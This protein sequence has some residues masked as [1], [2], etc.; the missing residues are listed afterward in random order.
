VTDA[1]LEDERWIAV[2]QLIA[3]RSFSKSSRLTSFLSYICRCALEG[4]NDE[5][6][7]QQIGIH[8]FE[9]PVNYNPGED[10]IVRTT[11]RQ[12]RQKLA[13]Y[14]QE[15]GSSDEIRVDIPRGGYH[16]TFSPLREAVERDAVGAV[17][18]APVV[19]PPPSGVPSNSLRLQ[20]KEACLVTLALMIGCVATLL[21][22]RAFS[23]NRSHASNM[24]WSSLFT[25]ER[26]TL[27]VT[28]DAGLN[29]YNNLART[30][31]SLGSYV[32]NTY[33]N[34]PEAQPPP[35]YTWPSLA[36]RRYVSFV[37]LQLSDRLQTLATSYQS[38][39]LV[40]FSRDVTPEDLR[41]RNVVLAGSGS[42]NPWIAM[43][44]SKLNFHLQYDGVR[45]SVSVLNSRPIAGEPAEFIAEASGSQKQGYSHGFAYIALTDNLE[46]NGKVLLVEGS[47]VAGVD[48]A[49]SFLM[50]DARMKPILAQ[51]SKRD[52]H[53]EKFEV[54]LSADFLKSSSPDAR[55]LAT[56]F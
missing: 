7:E 4:R 32:N 48:A 3:S 26:P 31:V 55:L 33:L 28:G 49:V 23:G 30:Q 41:N 38:S 35:G 17:D 56:R 44:D 8:G 27:F 50:N 25:S 40:K 22:Q 10:N 45:N 6:T 43:F 19:Q 39:Y 34:T 1:L 11:A 5:I 42:Y 24:L 12:L 54:L 2:Q 36:T 20:W 13:L 14:Y 52:G 29:M 51:A 16:P 18:L 47:T 53:P 37:D 21:L 46:G 15:E 9:R